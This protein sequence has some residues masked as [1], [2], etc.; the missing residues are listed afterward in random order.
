MQSKI[1][2]AEWCTKNFINGRSMVR[3]HD[4]RKQLAEICSRDERKGGLGMDIFSTCQDDLVPFLKNCCAGLFLNAAVRNIQ[5]DDIGSKKKARSRILDGN[6]A[7]G[8]YKT[9]L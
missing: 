4:V 8:K 5:T 1:P 9:K 3:A 6:G 2:H 7:A